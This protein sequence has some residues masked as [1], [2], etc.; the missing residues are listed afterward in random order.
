MAPAGEPDALDGE[1]QDK[2]EGKTR[3]DKLGLEGVELR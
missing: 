1:S 3:I 2:R